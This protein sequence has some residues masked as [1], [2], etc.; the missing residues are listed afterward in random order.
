MHS[1][2]L[3]VEYVPLRQFPHEGEEAELKKPAP[4]SKHAAEPAGEY[5]PASQELQE[6]ASDE[7]LNF[8]PSQV[9]HELARFEIS[10]Y[11]PGMHEVQEADAAPLYFPT[12]Q[13]T[14]PLEPEPEAFLPAAQSSQLTRLEAKIEVEYFP[15]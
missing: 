5:L 12:T 6:V 3:T 4:Q 14:H 1:K 13:L 8:P 15:V 10:E 2:D 11:L 9:L 7:E